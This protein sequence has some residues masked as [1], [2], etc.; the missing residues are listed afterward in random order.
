MRIVIDTNVLMAGLLK[1][2][3]IREILV[4][5][6]IH[7]FLP[8]LAIKEV[9]KYKDYLCKKSS[10]TI[11]ELEIL[12]SYLLENIKVIPVIKIKKYMKKAEN[13]MGKIDINDS[14]FVATCFAIN[15]DGIWS[16]DRHFK[17]QNK[18]RIFDIK[19]IIKFM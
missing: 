9:L 16:F 6:N 17:I 13:I 19:D 14:S 18:I 1:D 7:F 10:Y 15:A 5:K 11:N 12:L 8:D 3:I 2:S 4:S